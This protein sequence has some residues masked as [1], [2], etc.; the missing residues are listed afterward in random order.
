MCFIWILQTVETG[1]PSAASTS[2]SL[3]L[4]FLLRPFLTYSALSDVSLKWGSGM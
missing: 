3:Q 1:V 4:G 2:G